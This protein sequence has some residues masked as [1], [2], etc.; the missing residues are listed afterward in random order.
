MVAYAKVNLTLE[1]LGCLPDGYHR[2]STILQTIS[3]ADRLSFISNA[4]L[5]VEGDLTQLPLHENLVWKAGRALQNATGCKDGARIMLKKGIPVSSGLGGGS[6]DAATT[7]KALNLLWE[8]KLGREE[9]CDIAMTLGADVPFFLYGGT[10][11]AEGKGHSITPLPMLSPRWLVVAC[12]DIVLN[13]KTQKLYSLVSPENFTDGERTRRALKAIQ[14]GR[15][16]DDLLFNVFKPL[17]SHV[18]PH[19][20]ISIDTFRKTGASCVGL[21]GTGPAVY[22][23]VPHKERGQ[24]LADAI[25]QKG[26]HAYLA[27]TL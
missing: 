9:L 2:V 13:S 22:S 27:T 23:F 18:F 5:T 21:S 25:R 14:L 8:L 1:V 3:L 17:V 7:L 11:L 12:P 19:T 6:S 15:Q 24:K 10:A 4:Q 16:V 26:I 20:K